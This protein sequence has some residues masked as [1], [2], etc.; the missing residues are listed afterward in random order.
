M[1]QFTFP[2]ASI[3]F[4]QHSLTPCFMEVRQLSF[5]SVLLLSFLLHSTLT[6]ILVSFP[7]PLKFLMAFFS[8]HT[9]FH[10]HILQIYRTLSCCPW[11]WV[12][13]P[14]FSPPARTR[15]CPLHLLACCVALILEPFFCPHSP[16]LES[17]VYGLHIFIFFLLSLLPCFAGVHP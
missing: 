2:W 4:K 8:F 17:L 10:Y 9:V 15:T 11:Y 13:S 5:H 12:S 3:H 6:E 1:F 16:G 7:D 14:I